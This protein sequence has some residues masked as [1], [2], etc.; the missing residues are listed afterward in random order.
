M[1]DL[2]AEDIGFTPTKYTNVHVEDLNVASELPNNIVGEELITDDSIDPPAATQD[3]AAPV[4]YAPDLQRRTSSRLRKPPI[5]QIDF[6]TGCKSKS[7][8]SFLYSISKSVVT[9]PIGKKAI[10]CKWV[11]KIKYKADGQVERY[12]ARLVAKGYN[13]N[14]GLDYQET[15]SPV[16]KMVTVRT[17]ISMVAANGWSIQQI[18]VGNAFLQGDLYEEVYM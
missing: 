4:P 6:V 11:F 14:E 16:V 13:Q 5:W 12:K 17:V 10:G 9:L 3:I 2:V 8:H 15:F 1:S 7:A 18:D